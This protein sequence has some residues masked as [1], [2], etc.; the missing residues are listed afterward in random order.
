MTLEQGNHPEATS[1]AGPLTEKCTFFLVDFPD[2]VLI[3]DS[4]KKVGFLNRAAE[5]LFGDTLRRGDACPICSLVPGV[6][7]PDDQDT[8]QCC[9]KDGHTLRRE[10]LMLRDGQ[11]NLRSLTVTATPFR[12]DGGRPGGCFITLRDLEADVQ[13]HPTLQVQMATL[14]SIL[15]NFPL[16]FFMVAPDLTITYMNE[17]MEE[18]T[19]YS[20][21]EAVGK[22]SCK[23]II[24]TVQCNTRD[25]VL[26]QVMEH[27]RPM[28]GLRRVARDRQGRE[29]P[30]VVNASIITDS[31]GQVI[32]GFETLR[33]ITPV[34]EAERKIDLITELT[35]EGILMADQSQRIVFVNSKMAEI[36][37][38]PKQELIGQDLGEALTPQHR[39]MAQELCRKL[40]EGRP[41]EMQFC[42]TLD[43]R[44]TWPGEQRAFETCM[45]VSRIGRNILTCIYLRDLTERVRTERELYKTNIFLQNVIRCSVDGIVVVDVKGNVLIFN[46]GAE[47]ILGY[48]TE[49]MVGHPEMLFRFYPPETAKE[50]MRRMRSS[51]YGPRDK[52]IPAKSPSTTRPAT[53]CR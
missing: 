5:A 16:P 31:Q 32:G 1:P 49:E 11:A 39:R 27:R 25:C 22:L 51:R 9:L 14:N 28:S 30:V 37:D 26:R 24:N 47:R 34:V 52:L 21:E 10:P 19:G 41:Q 45:A 20:R 42:S 40:E 43:P 18:L 15:E 46:E 13:A 38:C 33:D 48:T 7:E 35:Q 12:P 6:A 50:M 29:I 36:L 44:P 53:R 4:R 23:T 17:R 2:P 8:V 3:T